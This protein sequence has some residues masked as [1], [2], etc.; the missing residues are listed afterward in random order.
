M[1]CLLTI[2]QQYIDSLQLYLFL[3]LIINDINVHLWTLL[4]RMA[5]MSSAFSCESLSM[6]HTIE[7][8][9]ADIE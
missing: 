2:C 6:A 5:D 7:Y 8:S 4:H 9:H 3:M 1:F